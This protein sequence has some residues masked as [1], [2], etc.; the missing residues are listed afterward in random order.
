MQ[1]AMSAGQEPAD[2]A[3]EP[4][5]WAP[6]QLYR[7]RCR[8][9][10]PYQA[11]FSTAYRPLDRAGWCPVYHRPLH[12]KILL[13]FSPKSCVCFRYL[14]GCLALNESHQEKS[15]VCLNGWSPPSRCSS[16]PC[17]YLN[18]RYCPRSLIAQAWLPALGCSWTWQ[19]CGQHLPTYHSLWM[20]L[21]YRASPEAIMLTPLLIWAR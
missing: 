1:L 12:P 16:H 21:C 19:G 9:A 15:G 17:Q 11:G 10:S 13:Y 6:T 4:G 5:Y 7:N 3:P 20:S 2:T 8:Q 18:R 14:K